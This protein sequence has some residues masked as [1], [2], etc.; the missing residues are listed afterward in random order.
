LEVLAS[1]APAPAS[2]RIAPFDV[3]AA[4][5]APTPRAAS[6]PFDDWSRSG[7]SAGTVTSNDAPLE[8][9][10][11][12]LCPSVRRATTRTW[13]ASET[14]FTSTFATSAS[15]SAWVGP[16]PRFVQDTE[17]RAAGPR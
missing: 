16:A 6:E 1:T 11:L 5:A 10:D 14:T 17:T 12:L 2:T 9:L 15:A 13:P 8:P 3:S 4:T 7:V